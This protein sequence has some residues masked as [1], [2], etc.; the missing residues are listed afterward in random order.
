MIAYDAADIGRQVRL[1]RKALGLTQAQLAGISG[2]GT[3]FI[4]EMERGKPTAQVGKVIDVLHVLGLDL[5][6]EERG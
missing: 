1:R 4:S 3:R 6:V 5:H 2:N